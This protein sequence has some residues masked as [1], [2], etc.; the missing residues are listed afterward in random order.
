MLL[1]LLLLLLFEVIN[2]RLMK[3]EQAIV[4][5][6]VNCG[7]NLDDEM[8]NFD[9]LFMLCLDLIVFMEC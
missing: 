3:T 4:V 9:K 8:M 5:A 2:E 7:L 1:L 6:V